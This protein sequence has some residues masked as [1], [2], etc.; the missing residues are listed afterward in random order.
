MG[1]LDKSSNESYAETDDLVELRKR[2][3]ALEHLQAISASLARAATVEETLHYILESLVSLDYCFAAF[4]TL[5]QEKGVLTD[6]LLSTIPYPPIQVARKIIPRSA[7]VPLIH[8]GN[9]AVRS[10]QTL[11]LQT[12][13]DLAEVTMPVI[14]PVATRL[15][16]RVA[17]LQAVAAVPVVVDQRPYG[18]WIAGSS[19]KGP[20]TN[21][22]LHVLTALAEVAGLAIERAQ[23]YD[24]LVSKASELEHALAQAHSTQ[25]RL[26]Q[27]ERLSAIECLAGN[28]AHEMNDPLQVVRARLEL[29]LEEI[30]TGRPVEREHLAV[31]HQEI[32]R[33]VQISRSLLAIQQFSNESH[34]RLDVSAIL[35]EMVQ[36][37]GDQLD[38]LGLTF[39][40]DLAADLPPVM[41]KRSHLQQI[42]FNLALNVIGMMP[43]GGAVHIRTDHESDGWVSATIAGVAEEAAAE[44]A[45][46]LDALGNPDT[47]VDLTACRVII[48]VHGGELVASKDQQGGV[49]FQVRLPA[50]REKSDA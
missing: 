25:D 31:A 3:S 34:T 28:I 36:W 32:K 9:L 24:H 37:M 39:E 15:V 43:S 1:M 18:V 14:D 41:G 21:E 46:V 23:R 35:G 30:D 11:Q 2:V 49:S 20:L 48:E 16:Q 44:R 5:D 8:S 50:A 38:R 29:A 10:L 33:I 22:D 13:E 17:G 7:E 45:G 27:S 40:T 6:Y 12:T 4:L 47:L 26:I 19:D 42:F